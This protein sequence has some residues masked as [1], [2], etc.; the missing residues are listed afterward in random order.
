[1]DEEAQ[2]PHPMPFPARKTYAPVMA[3]ISESE[4]SWVL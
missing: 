4:A 3:L 2:T 1:M